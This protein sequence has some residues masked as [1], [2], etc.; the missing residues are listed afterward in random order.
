MASAAGGRVVLRGSFTQAYSAAE[1]ER[2]L[3]T[4]TAQTV[5]L[6]S[7]TGEVVEVN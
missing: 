7:R 5:A 6:D 1:P 4:G 2:N 3:V